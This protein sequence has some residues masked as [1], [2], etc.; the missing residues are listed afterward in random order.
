MIDTLLKVASLCDG[1]RCDM[2]MLDIN[3]VHKD[4]WGDFIKYPTPAEEILERAVEETRKVHHDFVFIAEVYWGLEWDIQEMGFDYTYDKVL[5]D[6]LRFSS[7]ESIK[8]HLNAEHLYQMRSIRFITNHDEEVPLKAF[9][10]E[11]SLAAA[12]II[13]T[14]SGARMYEAQQIYGFDFRMPIQYSGMH[15]KGNPEITE[16]YRK[17][18]NISDNPAFHGGQWTLKETQSVNDSLTNN[19]ILYW[20]WVQGVEQKLVVINYSAEQSVCRIDLSKNRFSEMKEEFSGNVEPNPQDL[21]KNGLYLDLKPYEV[22]IYT[23]SLS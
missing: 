17:L 4:I 11:K 10:K 13:S 9:G 20:T 8:S 15:A 5:Y 16:Y 23:L 22:K 7:A 12:A 6:R 3:K 14:I 21:Y 19:N 1:V 2:A 18:L